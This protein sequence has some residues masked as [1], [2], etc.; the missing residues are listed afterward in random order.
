MVFLTVY[1]VNLQ[2]TVTKKEAKRPEHWMRWGWCIM[3][4]KLWILHTG[5]YCYLNYSYWIIT[6][7]LACNPIH[8][9]GSGH[10]GKKTKN[11]EKSKLPNTH[12]PAW[13]VP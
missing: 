7:I 6:T 1:I 5:C 13:T 4:G 12:L 10:Q 11:T 2:S 8:G 3:T 9:F